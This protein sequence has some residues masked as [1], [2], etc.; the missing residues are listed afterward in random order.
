MDIPFRREGDARRPRGST[1]RPIPKARQFRVISN[2]FRHFDILAL[3][4]IPQAD[5][6]FRGLREIQ[7]DVLK[8]EMAGLH[9]HD[10]SRRAGAFKSCVFLALDRVYMGHAFRLN[11]FEYRRIKCNQAVQSP[12]AFDAPGCNAQ[13]P[14]AA[15]DAN[16][17]PKTANL[18][19]F[20]IALPTH[21]VFSILPYIRHDRSH[22]RVSASS[23][24]FKSIKKVLFL[25]TGLSAQC[26]VAGRKPAKP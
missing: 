1:E 16:A 25:L 6:I 26:G 24:R 3:E 4:R 21:F 7:R 17:S 14:S 22:T 19:F 5:H 10:F 13:A 18:I 12:V 9:E 2:S 15:K 23:K 20:I 11:R 8:K